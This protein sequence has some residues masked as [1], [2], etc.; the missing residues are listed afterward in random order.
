MPALAREHNVDAPCSFD[1]WR[2]NTRRELDLAA[3][4]YVRRSC[5]DNRQGN[6]PVRPDQ[7]RRW[8][9]FAALDL[10]VKID[11]H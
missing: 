11:C 2:G 8:E 4:L 9:E 1:G 10:V 3:G 5:F 7:L 6:G